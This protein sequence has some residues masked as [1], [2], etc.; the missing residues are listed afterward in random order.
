MSSKT[1]DSIKS[2]ESKKVES[3]KKME[4]ETVEKIVNEKSVEQSSNEEK[5]DVN[6]ASKEVVEESVEGNNEP[7][8]SPKSTKKSE[9]KE[10]KEKKVP[11][12]RTITSKSL[13]K[14]TEREL[15]DGLNYLIDQKL[16]PKRPE[17]G[18][19]NKLSKE[20]LIKYCKP[21]AMANYYKAVCDQRE[22]R[23]K[24][25]PIIT[26]KQ[27]RIIKKLNDYSVKN[28]TACIKDLKVEI[29]NTYAMKKEDLSQ[30][31]ALHER[32]HDILDAVR[33]LEKKQA[34]ERENAK[35][36]KQKQ[37]EEQDSSESDGGSSQVSDSESEEEPVK[38]SKSKSKKRERSDSDES[39][40]ESSE[41]VSKK[42]KKR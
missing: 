6:E 13:R 7:E 34:E 27:R 29:K 36:E 39:D 18:P 28:I 35:L 20:T 40:S 17:L 42:S 32:G 4:K 19:I 1:H 30:A 38:S 8:T 25:A 33:K 5:E 26:E 9:K 31:V 22:E 11:I 23:E 12:K 37:E 21:W 15:K 41:E 16:V 24:N 10:K 3:S 2:K 14:F